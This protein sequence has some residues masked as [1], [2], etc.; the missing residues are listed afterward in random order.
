MGAEALAQRVLGDEGL[1]L[2]DELGV[3]AER[4]AGFDP[5]FESD[6]AE[7]LETSDLGLSERLVC[8]VGERGATPKRQCLVEKR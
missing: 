4:E 5:L 3:Q 1:E 2:A 6:E 8:E 7:L